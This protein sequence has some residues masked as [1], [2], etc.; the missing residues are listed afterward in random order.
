MKII[1]GEKMSIKK[2]FKF[3]TTAQKYFANIEKQKQDR[4]NYTL[5]ETGKEPLENFSVTLLPKFNNF[6]YPYVNLELKY[7][8]LICELDTTNELIKDVN[9]IWKKIINQKNSPDF[10][11][12]NTYF[13]N[14]INKLSQYI[15][16]DLKHFI[17]ETIATIWIIYNNPQ[18]DSI[19][20]ADTGDYL[21]D[22]NNNFKILDNFLNLFKTMN[23]LFNS[24]KHSYLNSDL[25]IIGRD[26]PCFIALGSKSRALSSTATPY[27]IS[28][29]SIINEFNRFYKDSFILIDQLTK[30]YKI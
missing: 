5:I 24:Y 7:M 22:G 20:I 13:F 27:C 26:E 2:F 30:S 9:D 17:D 28:M 3:L 10:F 12:Y 11:I 15:V 21:K 18:N 23:D 29:N 14:K 6:K 25:S 19:A 8:R 1:K 4:K 16:F